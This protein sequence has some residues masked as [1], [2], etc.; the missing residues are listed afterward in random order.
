MKYVFLF[1]L[2]AFSQQSVAQ[3]KTTKKRPI[4]FVEVAGGIAP[5]INQSRYSID[6]PRLMPLNFLD[7]EDLVPYWSLRVGLLPLKRH[8]LA[9]GVES[10]PMYNRFD[11]T[12]DERASQGLRYEIRTGYYYIHGQYAFNV[13]SSTRLRLEPTVQFGVGIANEDLSKRFPTNS[14]RVTTDLT[15]QAVEHIVKID[16][17]EQRRAAF[18]FGFGN[19]FECMIWPDHLSLGLEFKFLLAPYFEEGLVTHRVA[20]QY[21]NKPVLNFEM[22]NRIVYFNLG[23]R[24]CCYF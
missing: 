15:G 18:I 7:A 12:G 2:A 17:V 21:G 13:L 9:L 8:S 4:I 3:E 6:D 19:N 5:L 1:F 14:R 24:L 16:L 11:Y 20:Y 23:V 22:S 10:A